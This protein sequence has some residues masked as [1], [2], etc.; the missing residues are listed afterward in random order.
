MNVLFVIA[1]LNAVVLTSAQADDASIPVI[2]TQSITLEKTEFGTY[3]HMKGADLA[4]FM[5]VLPS[6]RSVMGSAYDR[7]FKELRFLGKGGA[8]VSITCQDRTTNEGGKL[9]KLADGVE[10]QIYIGQSDGAFEG[11]SFK[12]VPNKACTK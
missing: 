1:A 11:D 2:D 7:H 6:A 5:A 3:A 8:D 9:V 12:F 4:N 10:C